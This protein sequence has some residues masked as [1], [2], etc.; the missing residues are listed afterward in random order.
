MKNRKIILILL[1]L[2]LIICA[3]IQPAIAY[4][5]TFTYAKGGHPIYLR[6][7]TRI[8][9]QFSNKVKHIIIK[10]DQNS[11][12]VWV[13]A[14]VFY[15]Y[16]GIK[17]ITIEGAANPSK[18]QRGETDENGYVYYNYSEPLPGGG[19]TEEL[20]VTID[21]KTSED[22]F[23]PEEE[24]KFNVIVI[25]E[26]TPVRYDEDGSILPVDWNAPL[27]EYDDNGNLVPVFTNEEGNG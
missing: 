12:P 16:Q 3:D 22:G 23:T 25:Y 27:Y 10:S 21:I 11:E 2:A 20:T 17:D 24:E 18:W 4:F 13:R 1:V 19:E 15:A 5:T 8:E 6:D 14:K 9:E 7:T 26:S